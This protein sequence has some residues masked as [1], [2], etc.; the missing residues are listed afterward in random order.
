MIFIVYF[1]QTQLK[2]VK[3]IE[4]MRVL[5]SRD[6]TIYEMYLIVY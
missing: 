6:H 4:M 3:L 1:T 2:C 5:R